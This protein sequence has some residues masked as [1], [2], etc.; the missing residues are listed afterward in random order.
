VGLV[1][2]VALLFSGWLN[3]LSILREFASQ[4]ER[5]IQEALQH[6]YLFGGSII[7]GVLIGVPLGIWAVHSKNADKPIFLIA[8]IFQTIPSLA[9]FGLL[10][11]PLAALSLSFPILRELGIKGIGA[12]PAVIALII[13]SLFPIIQ[14]TYAGLRHVDPGVIEAGKGMGMRRFQIFRSVEA[15]LAA[16]IMVEGVRTAAVQAVG[17]TAVAALIGAGGLGQFIFQGLGQA[18]SDLIILGAIPIIVLALLVDSLMKIL[19]DITTP[20]GL[21][22]RA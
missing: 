14:N 22:V 2:V 4:R 17:N 15:P 10:I 8:S 7:V 13:Y 11:A 6:I 5:F 9:L 21:R 19:V 18:A 20:R 16:P 3:E 12:A 1:V